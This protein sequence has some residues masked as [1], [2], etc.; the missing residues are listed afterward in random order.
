M[1]TTKRI[2]TAIIIIFYS[3]FC[4]AQMTDVSPSRQI[5]YSTLIFEGTVI[6]EEC[7]Y[8]K[9]YGVLTCCIL[10]INKIYKGSPNIKLGTI[11]VITEQGGRVG[12]FISHPSEVGP[13]LEKGKNYIIIGAVADSTMLHKMSTDNDITVEL[14]DCIILSGNSAVWDRTQYRTLDDLYSVFKANG[15]TLQEEQK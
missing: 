1:K 13:G 10:Q 12:N 6:Q 7:F 5:K 14:S 4:Y 2:I 3:T 9:L 15:L 11:K 8:A